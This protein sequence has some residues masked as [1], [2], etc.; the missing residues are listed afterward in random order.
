MLFILAIYYLGYNKTFPT[1]K[2][3]AKFTSFSTICSLVSNDIIFLRKNMT[4]QC[5]FNLMFF[6]QCK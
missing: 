3:A 6:G 2:K 5:S 1:K 4:I